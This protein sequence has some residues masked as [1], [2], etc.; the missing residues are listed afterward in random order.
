MESR[1]R[2]RC[3]RVAASVAAGLL[4]ISVVLY[5]PARA[6]TFAD[7][8]MSLERFDQVS[9]MTGFARPD[10]SPARQTVAA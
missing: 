8:M 6:E 10:T 4:L 9:E 2:R 1:N 5:G 3:A 7:A